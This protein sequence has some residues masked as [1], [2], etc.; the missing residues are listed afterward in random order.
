M[1]VYVIGIGSSLYY[2]Q[3]GDVATDEQLIFSAPSYDRLN[4]DR[5]RT[6]IVYALSGGTP[7]INF[8]SIKDPILNEKLFRCFNLLAQGGFAF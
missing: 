4:S 5:E 2:P 7:N 1:H 6:R 8:R 3:Y